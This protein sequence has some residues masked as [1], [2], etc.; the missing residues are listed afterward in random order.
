MGVVENVNLAV[1][2]RLIAQQLHGT[3]M[4]TS[5]GQPV[6]IGGL[7]FYSGSVDGVVIPFQGKTLG[8][9]NILIVCQECG[10]LHEGTIT[11]PVLQRSGCA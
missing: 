10:C 6:R 4:T 2:A 3:G 9:S 8:L 5:S 11:M 7:S 1:F